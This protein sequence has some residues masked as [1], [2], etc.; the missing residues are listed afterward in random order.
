MRLIVICVFSTMALFLTLF[1][2]RLYGLSRANYHVSHEFLRDFN[3]GPQLISYRGLS[4]EYPENTL[5]ALEAAR[6][7]NPLVV[8]FVD[9]QQS[10]D[11]Y[12]F[13]MADNTLDRTTNGLGKVK[14]HTLKEIQNLTIPWNE[15]KTSMKVPTLEEALASFP[16]S[17]FIL[18]IQ[19]NEKGIHKKI[20]T[21]VTKHQADKR[22]LIQSDYDII[23]KTIKKL[24]PL[25]LFGSGQ[26]E[27]TKLKILEGLFIET[28]SP[29]RGDIIVASLYQKKHGQRSFSQKLIKEIHRRQMKVILGPIHSREDLEKLTREG[30]DGILTPFL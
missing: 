5:E 1:G 15:Q 23:I 9:I 29:I 28:I 30:V 12:L 3:G 27:L 13:L 4:S 6:R 14:D 24:Q 10:K 26:T 20:V 17:R 8:F 16:T 2:L 19:A 21:I 18:N 22:V 11:G 7:I 25:W